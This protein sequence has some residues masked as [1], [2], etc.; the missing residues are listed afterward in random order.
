MLHRSNPD[1][2]NH[3]SL[4]SR[5]CQWS[6]S[7]EALGRVRGIGSWVYLRSSYSCLPIH[8]AK[9]L[10]RRDRVAEKGLETNRR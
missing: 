1:Y 4:A 2:S 10:G 8:A 3:S 7:V 5:K 6:P 9:G